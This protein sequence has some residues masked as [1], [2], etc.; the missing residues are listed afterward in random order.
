MARPCWH[1]GTCS[2]LQTVEKPDRVTLATFDAVA[3]KFARGKVDVRDGDSPLIAPRFE[4]GS[5]Y[6]NRERSL[7]IEY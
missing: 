3:F 4:I 5:G 1:F 2:W 7:L 6:L